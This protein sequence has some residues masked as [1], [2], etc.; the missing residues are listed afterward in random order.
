MTKTEWILVLLVG[1]LSACTWVKLSDAGRNVR[2]VSY[3]Q[4]D[5]CKKLGKATVSVL[6]K[7]GFISRSED[8]VEEE[9]QTLARNSA[10]EMGGDTMA[11][12]GAV[13]RGEQPFDVYQC[14]LEP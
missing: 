1:T 13:S 14:G 4:I 7:V 5:Q 12:A 2:L 10:A 11:A 8:K 3:D 9:L 6:D